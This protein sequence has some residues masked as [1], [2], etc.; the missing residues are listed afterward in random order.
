MNNLLII[1]HIALRNLKRN[2]WRSSITICSIGFGLAV[3]LW[4]QAILAGSS[5]NIIQTITSTYHGHMQIFRTDYHKDR[6]IQQ[7]FDLGVLKKAGILDQEGVSSTARLSLPALVSSGEQSLPVVLLGIDVEN[8]PKI[9]KIKDA[10]KEGDFLSTEDT[11]DCSTRA[12]YMS[13]SLAR[14]LNVSLGNKVVVLAQA[15]DGTLGNELLRLKGLFDT[16]SPEYD[17]SLVV[18]TLPCVRMIGALDGVHEV[19]FKIS[20]PH[21][22]ADKLQKSIKEKLP[23]DLQVL[24]WR[25]AEPRLAA[26]TNFNDACIVLVSGMLFIVISLGI[27][28][29]FLVSV[30]ERTV[31]FGVMMALGTSPKFV[32]ILILI[33]GLVLG[34]AASLFGIIA[35]I[36]V[37]TYHSY[38][39]YDLRPLVGSNLSVGAFQLN[40]VVYP[41]VEI[42]DGLR[43]TVI[44]VLVVTVSAF[45]P[46]LRAS[47]LK[48]VEAIRSN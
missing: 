40:L 21:I 9:T 17:K 10:L 3:I 31:E 35:G 23:K 43:A 33:E 14:L 46:A 4:L 29:A 6:M 15:A 37:I 22:N 5:Q 16:G 47:R 7:T 11:E 28:N 2:F 25:E 8:E 48:P 24:S 36:A 13:Q 34:L 38:V 42:M 19:A 41:V 12:A 30:F 20:D 39:G 27:L 18:T 26:M 32:V 1:F 45:Y 44:T